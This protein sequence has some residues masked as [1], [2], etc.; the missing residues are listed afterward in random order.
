MFSS[1]RSPTQRSRGLQDSRD[2]QG[3]AA[4]GSGR[5]P[6]LA[7]PLWVARHRIAEAE[8]QLLEAICAERPGLP[9]LREWHQGNLPPV[10]AP[11]TKGRAYLSNI[12]ELVGC[13]GPHWAISPGDVAIRGCRLARS[14]DERASHER[15]LPT[16]REPRTP[17]SCCPI[18]ELRRISVLLQLLG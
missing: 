10:L 6:Q 17:S 4:Q 14:C 13:G 3:R 11:P 18:A 15:G 9:G 2:R 8:A 12:R 7:A 5:V 16:D 1:G